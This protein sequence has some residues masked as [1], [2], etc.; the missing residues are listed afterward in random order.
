MA[1]QSTNKRV[2]GGGA[3]GGGRVPAGVGRWRRAAVAVA[4]LAGL[5]AAPGHAGAHPAQDA[6]PTPMCEAPADSPAAGDW[7]ADP[8]T[9]ADLTA[10]D[11]AAQAAS[12]DVVGLIADDEAQTLTVVADAAAPAQEVADLQERVEA[13]AGPTEV[14]VRL[15]CRP[16]DQ[17]EAVQEDLSS[18][19][20]GALEGASYAYEV[21]PATGTVAVYAD[22]AATAQAI[23]ASFGDQVSVTVAEL[24]R[25]SGGRTSD[26]SPHYGDARIT[27]G[28]VT[29]SSNFAFR[30]NVFG[31]RVTATAGHCGGS[32]WYSGGNLVGNVVYQSLPNPDIEMLYASGQN[33]TNVIYT[34]PCSPCT[35]T[36]TSKHDPGVS[37]LVCVGGAIT[38][39]DCGGTVMS[40]NATFCDTYGCTYGLTH[41]FML[42]NTQLCSSGDSGG[43][44]YQRDGSSEA[45]ANGLIVA[46][47]GPGFGG[48]GCYFHR[49]S[50]VEAAINSTLLTSP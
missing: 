3:S 44:V 29:C 49:I 19:H 22:D 24:D 6:S 14:E 30:N 46:S 5:V 8:Q 37:E 41:A 25:T 45:T 4:V 48:W 17:L 33:Q 27:S 21:D 38:L 15:S 18:L 16:L 23:G 35:R 42:G 10:V 34:D 28:G 7:V 11:Q 9:Q 43:V 40:T 1:V 20:D 13:A 31:T 12:A 39:A 32:S 50:Q 2:A 47:V 26:A 36:V